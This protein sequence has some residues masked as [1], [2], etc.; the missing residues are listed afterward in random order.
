[1]NRLSISFGM[2]GKVRRRIDNLMHVIPHDSVD[3]PSR[4]DLVE[5]VLSK[6]W[7]SVKNVVPSAHDLLFM[8]I[9]ETGRLG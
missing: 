7:F 5:I 4:V 8:G 2:V 1:M 9:P 6:G 3:I